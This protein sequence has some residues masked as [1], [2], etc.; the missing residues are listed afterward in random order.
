MQTSGVNQV[1][2]ELSYADSFE[3]ERASVLKEADKVEFS[4]GKIIR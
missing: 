3:F 4:C 1:A 2:E